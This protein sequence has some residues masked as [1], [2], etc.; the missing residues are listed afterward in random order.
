LQFDEENNLIKLNVVGEA[1][2]EDVDIIFCF[3]LFFET[4]SYYVAL[5]SLQ[6][7]TST[8][9]KLTESHSSQPLKY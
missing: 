9:L 5:A 4:R 1:V 6:L 8:S 2:S 7:V 3:V